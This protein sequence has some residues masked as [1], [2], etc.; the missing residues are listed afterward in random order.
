MKIE[1]KLD[2]WVDGYEE[3]IAEYIHKSLDRCVK[4]EVDTM[5][6]GMV[7]ENLE[8]L[9]V[10]LAR[11]MRELTPKKL[12]EYLTRLSREGR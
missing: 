8:S 4:A 2:D 3:S 12:D 10:D 5:I 1:I 7:R 6:S 9:K 11:K